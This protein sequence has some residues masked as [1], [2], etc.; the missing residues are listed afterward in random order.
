M[1]E[2]LGRGDASTRRASAC[3]ARCR[4]R[5]YARTGQRDRIGDADDLRRCRAARR[6]A[7]AE[8]AEPI[9]TPAPHGAVG[10]ARAHLMATT[11]ELCRGE[12]RDHDR[13]RAGDQRAIA[14]LAERVL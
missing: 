5:S 13:A 2:R 11:G 4:T 3:G 12:A 7:I 9:V 6:R 1:L 8:L 14:D 10:L